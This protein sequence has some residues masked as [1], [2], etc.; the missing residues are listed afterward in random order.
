[1]NINVANGY[2]LPTVGLGYIHQF[3]LRFGQR[4]DEA[5]HGLLSRAEARL[6]CSLT[7]RYKYGLEVHLPA[8]YISDGH[9]VPAEFAARRVADDAEIAFRK[10]S[11]SPHDYFCRVAVIPR[12]D[13]VLALLYTSQRRFVELWESLPEVRGYGYWDESDPPEDVSESEWEQRRLEWEQSLPLV[14]APRC[15]GQMGLFFQAMTNRNLPEVTASDMCAFAPTLE[16]RT[17]ALAIDMLYPEF[18]RHME[19]DDHQLPAWAVMLEFSE[20]IDG[21]GMQRKERKMDEVRSKLEPL[22]SEESFL[23][24]IPASVATDID[25]MIARL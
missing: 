23:A 14:G 16:E 13:H 3:L 19:H 12:Q 7:D 9:V 5:T 10:G 11:R 21:S 6:A 4:V 18:L 8:T 25:P 1:M 24:Q 2:R 15:P 22:P 17:M 20:W